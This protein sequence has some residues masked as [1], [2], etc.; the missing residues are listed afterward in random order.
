MAVLSISRQFGA[1]GKT[2]G[3]M[4]A[5]RMKYQFVDSG[6]LR[7]VAEEAK[8]SLEWVEGVEKEAGGYL[9]RFLSNL[10]SSDF[11]ER[12]VSG[13]AEDFDEKKYVTFL[14]KVIKRIA[15][16]DNVVFV[17]RGSQFIL[18]DNPN[19]LS[20]LLVAERKDRIQF[21][22]DH[23]QMDP[24]KA[25]R[26]VTRHEKKRA[27]FMTNFGHTNPDD[28]SH[29]HMV[30]NTSLL[31]LDMARD[32]ICNLLFRFIDETSSPIWD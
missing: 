24:G 30:L 12:H 14:Q 31:S 3:L 7:K 8:V 27:R 19:V 29:Y 20:V 4:V 18:K 9:M 17:G 21:L 23:Y 15:E 32:Q 26:M 5:R 2:I 1:G 13:S 6:I 28:P 25:E 11:I 22:V 16:E 10:V